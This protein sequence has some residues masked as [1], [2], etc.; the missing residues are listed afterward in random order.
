MTCHIVP[1]HQPR[2]NLG[3]ASLNHF[4]LFNPMHKCFRAEAETS[5]CSV[6]AAVV[7]S[8][9]EEGTDPAL[10]A[11]KVALQSHTLPWGLELGCP[12]PRWD[13]QAGKA[14]GAFPTQGG[15]PYAWHM[16]IPAP[17]TGSTL[18]P[19]CSA[20]LCAQRGLLRLRRNQVTTA[21]FESAD[22]SNVIQASPGTGLQLGWS[23]CAKKR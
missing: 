10:L 8:W 18:L 12:A 11:S 16:F 22:Q 19:T 2:G 3:A 1:A 21:N 13:A 15:A 9:E 23:G 20:P 6:K 17:C 14:A 4:A 5:L 7:L